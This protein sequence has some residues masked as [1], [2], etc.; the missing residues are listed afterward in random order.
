M[1][2]EIRR[3]NGDI[4]P[5]AERA[6]FRDDTKVHQGTFCFWDSLYLCGVHTDGSSAEDVKLIV[7]EEEYFFRLTAQSI[8]DVAEGL[9][10]GLD[11]TYEV[12]SKVVLEGAH[13]S[14]VLRET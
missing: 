5:V 10:V 2:D 9:F 4:S 8:S 1:I 6:S 14:F 3:V 7:V 13:Q 12:R 11:L